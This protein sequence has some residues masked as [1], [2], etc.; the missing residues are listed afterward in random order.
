MASRKCTPVKPHSE[1]NCTLYLADLGIAIKVRG[2]AGYKGHS[3]F[4]DILRLHSSHHIHSRLRI[5]VLKMSL[6]FT[7]LAAV[8]I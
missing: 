4:D 2:Y 3:W 6:Y 7:R 8:T 1:F 5:T